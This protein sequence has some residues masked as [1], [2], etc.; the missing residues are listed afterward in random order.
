MKT[1][2]I[3]LFISLFAIQFG[4]SQESIEIPNIFTPNADGIND[5]FFVENEGYENLACTIYNRHGQL[6][7]RFYGVNGNWDGRSHAGD[8]CSAGTYFVIVEVTKTDGSTE[9]F[10]GDVQLLR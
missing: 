9:S 10:Q 5:V 1:R 8:A 3:I 2:I 7:Y 6:V 4:Y